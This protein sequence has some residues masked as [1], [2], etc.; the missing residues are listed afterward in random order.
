MPKSL[1]G[2]EP[3]E[4]GYLSIEI[5][6]SEIIG[7]SNTIYW[8]FGLNEKQSKEACVFYILNNMKKIIF[9]L[10]LVRNDVEAEIYEDNFF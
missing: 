9:Y 8:I 2:K 6:E 4:E 10:Y 1:R 7:N 5:D 3:N